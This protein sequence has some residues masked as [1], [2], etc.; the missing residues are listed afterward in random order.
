MRNYVFPCY[1]LFKL[2]FIYLTYITDALSDYI[3][4]LRL[5]II[6]C[7]INKKK[8]ELWKVSCYYEDL[9]VLKRYKYNVITIL[10]SSC[11]RR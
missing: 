7:L 9:N 6:I 11:T 8:S 5:I 1:L 3:E 4:E 2:P 10:I